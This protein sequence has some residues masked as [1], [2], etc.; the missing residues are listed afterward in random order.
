MPD[1]SNTTGR[2]YVNASGSVRF[3]N[4]LLLVRKVKPSKTARDTQ[5]GYAFG[6]KQPV[7]HIEGR[8]T[9]EA[10]TVTVSLVEWKI[11]ASAVPDWKRIRVQSVVS[12]TDTDLGS[13]S[14]NHKNCKIISETPSESDGGS[15]GEALIDLE[16]LPLSVDHFGKTGNG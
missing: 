16:L 10:H 5:H 14:Y 15:T 3:N 11:F 1:Y 4:N 2:T 8:E 12:Y 6:Q 7:V 9:I 13:A